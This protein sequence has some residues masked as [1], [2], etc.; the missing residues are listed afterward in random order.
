MVRVVTAELTECP[1]DLLELEHCV[2][3][4]W[5]RTRRRWLQSIDF[6]CHLE[7]GQLQLLQVISIF[8]GFFQ[9]LLENW[10]EVIQL[11]EIELLPDRDWFVLP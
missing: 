8:T 1:D 5:S 7:H 10:R 6:S 2:R 11:C 4:E 3:D 9:F